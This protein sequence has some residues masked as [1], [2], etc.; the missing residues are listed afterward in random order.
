MKQILEFRFANSHREKL[1][2]SPLWSLL[3]KI[4]KAGLPIEKYHGYVEN[5]CT[6]GHL[7]LKVCREISI[8][9][10]LIVTVLLK[11]KLPPSRYANRVARYRNCRALQKLCRAPQESCSVQ[12]R[13]NF[14]CTNLIFLLFLFVITFKK[15][16]QLI[17]YPL[18]S[19]PISVFSA[20]VYLDF[21]LTSL[22]W[23]KNWHIYAKC[24]F[25]EIMS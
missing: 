17:E 7:I 16:T 11:S 8:I 25:Q 24:F 1:Q 2:F 19:E 23:G 6:Y 20:F 10:L 15:W 3:L 13:R 4:L 5:L 21:H 18:C 12:R 14:K 9:V 22:W